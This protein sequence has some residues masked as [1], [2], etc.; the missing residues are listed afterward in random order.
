V[1][2]HAD[3]EALSAYV[4]GEAPEW[5][6]H[7]AACAACRAS[8]EELRAV[9]A[10][11]AVPVEPPADPVRE[12][13]IATAVAGG[14]AAARPSRRPGQARWMFGAVAALVVVVVGV[15]A[16]LAGS[17]GSSSRR[18]DTAV[19]GP[20]IGSR[21]GTDA[22]SSSAAPVAPVADLGDIADAA[23]LLS[24]AGISTNAKSAAG[25]GGAAAAASPANSAASPLG[26]PG[27]VPPTAVGAPPCEA[28]ARAR[29]PSLGPVVYFATARH[30]GVPAVVLGFS[31]GSGS[32]PLTLL[33]LAQDGC[34]ELLRAVGP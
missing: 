3:F 28:V 26:S 10:A 6:A 15:A 12:A 1:T 2:E 31:N 13:A 19:A 30:G 4:D 14:R 32:P 25:A 33:L 5:G 34:A 17:G 29:Q 8:A 23:T 9:S 24:R 11:V 7:L 27:S 20:A 16:L 21:P 18:N 22:A